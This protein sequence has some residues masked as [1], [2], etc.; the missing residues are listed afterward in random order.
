MSHSV[1]D[2]SHRVAKEYIFNGEVAQRARHGEPADGGGYAPALLV[3]QQLG[4]GSSF[5]RQHVGVAH[6]PEHD[7]RRQPHTSPA[8]YRSESWDSIAHSIE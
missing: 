1:I 8:L 3:R 5:A 7:R 6:Q 4:L 2:V